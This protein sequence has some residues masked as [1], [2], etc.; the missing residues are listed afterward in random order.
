MKIVINKIAALERKTGVGYYIQ[1]LTE[2]LQLL[3]HNTNSPASLTSASPMN[4]Q[5]FTYPNGW[6]KEAVRYGRRIFFPSSKA[7]AALPAPRIENSA[8]LKLDNQEH[9]HKIETKEQSASCPST[10]SGS[11]ESPSRISW[12]QRWR[13]VIRS[14]ARSSCQKHFRYY[15][16]QNRIDIYHEPNYLPWPSDLPIITT[17]LDLSVLLYPQWHP[18]DRVKSYEKHFAETIRRTSHFLTISDFCKMQMIRQL[19]IHPNQITTTYMGVRPELTPVAL[20][21]TES[22]LRSLGLEKDFLLAVGTLEPRKNLIT[23]FKAFADLPASIRE[24]HPLVVVGG[25]GWQAGEIADYL[26]RYGKQLAIRHI[27]YVDEDSLVILYQNAACL[28]YPSHYEG[29]G[30]PPIEMLACGGCVLSSTAGALREVLGQHAVF[31]D[32][33]DVPAWREGIWRILTDLDYRQSL[34]KNGISF[35]HS[36][37]WNR[38]AEQTLGVYRSLQKT[39]RQAA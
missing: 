35:A 38:C 31:F 7:A 11:T 3:L 4:D 34:K 16:Q 30:L 18:F 17:I 37:S 2:S 28:L 19:G 15:C 12:K 14:A 8:I 24:K 1:N 29:F 5:L 27:D 21:K 13:H 22:V 25:W 23:I 10:L 20:E 39:Q 26:D 32:P 33:H 9:D 6:V 36:Y